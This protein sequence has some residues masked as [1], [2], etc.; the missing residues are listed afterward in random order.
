M[1]TTIL[2]YMLWPYM[3][4]LAEKMLQPEL[5]TDKSWTYAWFKAS[6][7]K[8]MRL[9]VFWVITQRVEVIFYWHLRTTYWSHLQG[10]S[11]WPLKMGR[12]GFSEASV[13]NYNYLLHNNI[14]ERSS[15]IISSLPEVQCIWLQSKST[16]YKKSIICMQLLQHHFGTLQW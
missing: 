10:L 6:V 14:E 11:F 4:M 7:M 15:Q 12:I 5:S 9:V 13:R 2:Y 1:V 8:Q 3:S 16:I